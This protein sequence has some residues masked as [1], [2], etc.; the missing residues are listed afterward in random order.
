MRTVMIYNYYAGVLPLIWVL[1]GGSWIPKAETIPLDELKPGLKAM[2]DAFL[3]TEPDI[4]DC[5][6]SS[7][8]SQDADLTRWFVGEVDRVSERIRENSLTKADIPL[9]IDQ[10]HKRV[11]GIVERADVRE[12]QFKDELKKLQAQ[13]IRSNW[14]GEEI[15]EASKEFAEKFAK[16]HGGIVQRGGVAFNLVEKT[17][18]ITVRS[19]RNGDDYRTDQ[20][21]GVHISEL[22]DPDQFEWEQT[23]CHFYDDESGEFRDWTI[24]NPLQKHISLSGDPKRKKGKAPF[25]KSRVWQAFSMDEFVMV[26]L[27]MMAM[28]ESKVQSLLPSLMT[29]IGLRPDSLNAKVFPIDEKRIDRLIQGNHKEVI[30]FAKAA[31]KNTEFVL[32]DFCSRKQSG[33]RPFLSIICDKNDVTRPYVVMV[34][35]PKDGITHCSLRDYHANG[36]LSFYGDST[37]EYLAQPS[38]AAVTLL[39]GLHHSKPGPEVF[40]FRVP[41]GWSWLDSTDPDNVISYKADGTSNKVYTVK[42]GE[43]F[44]GTTQSVKLNSWLYRSILLGFVVGSAFLVWRALQQRKENERN[45]N[46][47]R[48]R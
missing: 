2:F 3:T 25:L 9:A 22:I 10:I 30:L 14:T 39:T 8:S 29:K 12:Q 7:A 37:Q 16:E 40:E 5:T 38:F 42:K 44:R 4:Y 47:Y 46:P 18:T 32:L 45:K 43:D 48:I 17:G 33:K 27:V 1:I 35:S 20:K 6:F 19:R 31:G 21:L 28:D 23:F 24:L 26:S 36:E 15:E 13:G 34:R 41:E 11:L